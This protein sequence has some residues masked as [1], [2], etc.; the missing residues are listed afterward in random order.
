MSNLSLYSFSPP[1][2]AGILILQMSKSDPK[3]RSSE[4]GC[5]APVLTLILPPFPAQVK[6]HHTFCRTCLNRERPEICSQL[7]WE[8][9]KCL[10]KMKLVEYAAETRPHFLVAYGLNSQSAILHQTDNFLPS[11]PAVLSDLSW[12]RENRKKASEQLTHKSHVHF[13]HK[14]A[15]QRPNSERLP[16]LSGKQSY[17]IIVSDLVSSSL[18]IRRR[19]Q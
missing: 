15:L 1:Y 16:T 11:T 8:Y 3:E 19:K 6:V 14:R 7:R 2:R 18:Q 13:S 4:P 9:F 12:S 10:A 17:Q 5:L